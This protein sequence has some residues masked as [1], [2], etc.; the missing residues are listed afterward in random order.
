MVNATCKYSLV[1]KPLGYSKCPL[2][3]PPVLRNSS[4]TSSCVGTRCI[5]ISL[6][7]SAAAQHLRDGPQHDLPIESQG[8]SIDILHVHSHPGLEV[9]LIAAADDP[10]AR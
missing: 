9:H 8:P 5:L 10:Q 2:R 7:G 3:R 1:C 4:I 6:V